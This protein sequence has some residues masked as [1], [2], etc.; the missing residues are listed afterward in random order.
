MAAIPSAG[1][2]QW[3]RW[4]GGQGTDMATLHSRAYCGRAEALPMEWKVQTETYPSSSCPVPAQGGP[5]NCMGFHS[6]GCPQQQCL[7][8][9]EAGGIAVWQKNTK[10]FL[11]SDL[12]CW[13]LLVICALEPKQ[14]EPLVQSGVTA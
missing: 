9:T 13:H 2:Q 8:P 11:I 4:H 1:L 5:S 6:S 12:Q 10:G 3:A 7:M 14:S